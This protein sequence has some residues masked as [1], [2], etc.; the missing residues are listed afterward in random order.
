MFS[1]SKKKQQHNYP[2]YN[3]SSQALQLQVGL[4]A[5]LTIKY[6]M[7]YPPCNKFRIV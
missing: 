3:R 1:C 6:I 5:T 2:C 7:I 4:E